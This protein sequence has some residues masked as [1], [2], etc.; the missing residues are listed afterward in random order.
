MLAVLM[1]RF[2]VLGLLLCLGS[3]LVFPGL[4]LADQAQGAKG[5][6]GARPATHAHEKPV[7]KV[8]R[9]IRHQAKA[10]KSKAVATPV[11][12]PRLD[13]SLPVELVDELEPEVGDNAPRRKNL[14]PSMF[15]QEPG[16]D[17]SF[18]LNGRLISNEMQLQL[19]NDSQ[20]EV[21]GAAI[22]FQFR[23]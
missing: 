16:A 1:K 22:E 8:A 9:P 21:E 20:R 3:G 17:S 18:Q 4:T 7:K 2:R 11:P 13:L 19:R 15:S 6:E 5:A 14:L 12:K 10:V 23:Q